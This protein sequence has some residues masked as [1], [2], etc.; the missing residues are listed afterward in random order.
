MIGHSI[1]EVEIIDGE[2]A[3]GQ[4]LKVKI[5]DPDG[6]IRWLRIGATELWVHPRVREIML[7][8]IGIK[9]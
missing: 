2:M 8:K 9:R 1:L 5:V 6:E 4:A 3:I 7:E